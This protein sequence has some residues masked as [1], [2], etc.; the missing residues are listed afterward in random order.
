MTILLHKYCILELKE[1]YI[2]LSEQMAGKDQCGSQGS[3]SF[4]TMLGPSANETMLGPSTNQRGNESATNVQSMLQS[5][6]AQKLEL[7]REIAE[8]IKQRNIAQSRLDAGLE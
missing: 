2:V 3:Q 7:D 6:H 5:F 4:E 1:F 8:T